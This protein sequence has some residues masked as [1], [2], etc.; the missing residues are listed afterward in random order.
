MSSG[1][2]A[3]QRLP[4]LD[5]D[6]ILW[7]S[8]TTGVE[9]GFMGLFTEWTSLSSNLL[10]G[11]QSCL[12][13]RQQVSLCGK[14]CMLASLFRHLG[15]RNLK[16]FPEAVRGQSLWTLERKAKLFNNMFLLKCNYC[17]LTIQTQ[18]Q[19][20]ANAVMVK[21]RVTVLCLSLIL[22][23]LVTLN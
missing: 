20:Q 3:G 7:L 12:A 1:G 9:R 11:H 22:V 6:T 14:A 2:D 15:H 21:H 23:S 18:R 5:H 10:R 8:G 16:E 13:V 4:G 19:L 17:Y